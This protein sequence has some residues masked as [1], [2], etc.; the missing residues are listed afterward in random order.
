[1]KKKNKNEIPQRSNSNLSQYSH[2]LMNI[3]F[4]FIPSLK[5]YLLENQEHV[6]SISSAI[7]SQS[8]PTSQHEILTYS[9]SLSISY[10]N[11]PS[12]WIINEDLRDYFVVNGFKQNTKYKYEFL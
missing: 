12:V 10:S 8:L 2:Q 1:M 3:D 6:P 5:N 11:D 9:E 4:N 7:Q